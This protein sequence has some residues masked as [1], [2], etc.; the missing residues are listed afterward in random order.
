[1]T[2]PYRAVTGKSKSL[3]N[4]KYLGVFIDSKIDWSANILYLTKKKSKKI[5]STPT[6]QQTL[7]NASKARLLFVSN[8]V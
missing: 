4:V 1:M 8:P 3:T 6:S 5:E 7:V 2:L